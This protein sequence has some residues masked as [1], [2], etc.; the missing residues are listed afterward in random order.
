MVVGAVGVARSEDV[1][2]F[3]TQA[4]QTKLGKK[5]V[6]A[7]QVYKWEV[8]LREIFDDAKNGV[9]GGKKFEIT[10]ANGGIALEYNDDYPLDAAVRKVGDDT[11]AGIMDGSITTGH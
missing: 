1:A 5:I 11:A 3:G 7:S 9:L 4:N 2:W 6:V 10:L 8:V